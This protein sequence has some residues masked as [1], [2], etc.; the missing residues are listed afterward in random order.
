VHV[1][2]YSALLWLFSLFKESGHSFG[3]LTYGIEYQYL[4]LNSY[5][6]V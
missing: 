2:I 3:R 4:R 5:N 1:V 6:A